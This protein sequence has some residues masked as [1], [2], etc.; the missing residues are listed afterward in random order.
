[1]LHPLRPRR[2]PSSAAPSPSPSDDFRLAPPS[3]QSGQKAKTKGQKAKI[4]ESGLRL[5]A[6]CFLVF[7]LC[8]DSS[9]GRSRWKRAP[10]LFGE[11]LAKLPAAVPAAA[12]ERQENHQKPCLR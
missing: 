8:L 2:R 4:P 9:D 7:A 5:F 11:G 1:M 6:L 12:K 3:L 10:N